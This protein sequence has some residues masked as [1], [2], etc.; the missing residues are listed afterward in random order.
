MLAIIYKPNIMKS[1]IKLESYV[2]IHAF[3][4][5]NGKRNEFYCNKPFNKYS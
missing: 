3:V 4:N 5:K 2:L 1:H